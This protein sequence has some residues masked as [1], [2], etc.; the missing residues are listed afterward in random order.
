MPS[1]IDRTSLSPAYL[2]EN[3]SV[4]Y[5]KDFFDSYSIREITKTLESQK[6]EPLLHEG[7]I[8]RYE[9]DLCPKDKSV[10]E[11][12]QSISNMAEIIGFSDYNIEI[13]GFKYLVGQF[14]PWHRDMDRHK[15]TAIAYFG[16]FS[17][18]EYVYEDC[19]REN[20]TIS[21][22]PGSV[23]V[24]INEVPNGSIFNPR[25]KVNKVASGTRYCLVVSVVSN[26]HSDVSFGSS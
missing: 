12:E 20:K 14:V 21:P 1:I 6:F 5:I 10:L 24:S 16:N 3:G 13:Y 7:H 11:L 4:F 2:E 22:H 18:G 15:I 9:T 25:H 23:I 19:L 8:S 26:K 17:G